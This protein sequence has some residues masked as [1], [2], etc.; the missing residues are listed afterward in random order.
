MIIW[1]TGLSG[2]GKSTLCEAL[3]QLIRPKFPGLVVLDGDV[4][5]SAAGNDLSHSEEDRIVQFYRLQGLARALTDQG[6]IVI[7][8][9]VYNNKELLASNREVLAKYFEVFLE[10][11]LELVVARDAKQLYAQAK[12]GKMSDVVGID[13]VAH[14][15]TKPDLVLDA[16]LE[17]PPTEMAAQVVSRIPWLGDHF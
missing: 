11:P 4:V 2:V 6:L 17:L 15:P 12:I 10:A 8:A 16:S 14:K 9:A 3:D 7:V 13:I 5:R 1:L